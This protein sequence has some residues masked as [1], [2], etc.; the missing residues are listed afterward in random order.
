[1]V[2]PR[3]TINP[4]AARVSHGIEMKLDEHQVEARWQGIYDLS[5]RARRKE[6]RKKRRWREPGTTQKAANRRPRRQESLSG[7]RFIMCAR[8]SMA[9]GR[10][11]KRLPSACRKPGA[12]E[13]GCLRRSGV[14]LRFGGRRREIWREGGRRERLPKVVPERRWGR[15]GGR[16]TTQLPPGNWRRKRGPARAAADPRLATAPR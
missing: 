6:C 13:C 11:S 9:R 16:G 8:E 3:Y 5:M 14:P 12:R 15:C 10:S 2:S 1:M 4:I 7:K